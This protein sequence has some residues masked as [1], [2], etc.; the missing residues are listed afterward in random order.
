MRKLGTLLAGTA[1]IAM[2]LAS[3]P[4]EARPWKHGH[5]KHFKHHHQ[6]HGKHWRHH[7]RDGGAVALGLFG[8]LAGAAIAS[9][10][11]PYY[12]SYGYPYYGYSYP[13]YGYSY[14]YPY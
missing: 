7:R 4:A 1:V 2:A 8:A 13:S 9:A 12:Y 14:Y 5:H 11:Q 6:H 3:V 10:A